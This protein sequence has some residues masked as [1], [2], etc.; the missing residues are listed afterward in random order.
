MNPLAQQALGALPLGDIMHAAKNGSPA[1]LSLAGRAIGLG[2]DDQQ[3][4]VGGRV[5]WWAITVGALAVG[6]VVGVRVEAKAP[7]SVPKFL[8]GT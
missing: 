2:A 7:Q 1:L 6:F 5:P 8:K 4:L 3:A